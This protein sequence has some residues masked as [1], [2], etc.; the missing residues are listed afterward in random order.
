MRQHGRRIYVDPK[1]IS[2]EEYLVDVSI[3]IHDANTHSIADIKQFKLEECLPVV[4]VDN[5]PFTAAVIAETQDDL[6]FFLAPNDLRPKKVYWVPVT[7]LAKVT[8]EHF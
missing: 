5:G 2:K 7:E 3:K 6:D 8:G 4:M 1:G